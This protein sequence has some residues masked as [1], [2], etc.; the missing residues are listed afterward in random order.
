ILGC[1]CDPLVSVPLR[2]CVIPLPPSP[3]LTRVRKMDRVVGFGFLV[4]CAAGA[5]LAGA[6]QQGV[7]QTPSP[8][9]LTQTVRERGSSVT[10]AF[11]GWYYDKDGS[12]RLLVGY[13]NRN[14][15]QEFDIPPGPDNRIEPGGP[16]MGQPTHFS[17]GRQWG[18]FTI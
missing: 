12:E 6:G 5:T 14:T 7:G 3:L 16:D 17:T 13:F 10:P 1:T 8:L 9:P 2:L 11:E 4:A 15:K 18:V